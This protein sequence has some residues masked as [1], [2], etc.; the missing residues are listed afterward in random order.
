MA[1]AA[2]DQGCGKCDVRRHRRC[3]Q[4]M[5]LVRAYWA[6]DRAVGEELARQRQPNPDQ[7][8]L[9]LESGTDEGSAR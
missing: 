1:I 9:D 7:G 3:E 6:A 2:H 4:G 5:A 8:M